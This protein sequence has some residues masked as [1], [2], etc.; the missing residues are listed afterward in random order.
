MHA[1]TD[2]PVTEWFQSAVTAEGDAA[3]D[4]TPA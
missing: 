3:A 2:A 1:W 4:L